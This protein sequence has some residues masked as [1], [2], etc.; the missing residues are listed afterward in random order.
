MN[1][2]EPRSKPVTLDS[3]ISELRPASESPRQ[4]RVLV[5][6]A[7]Y[8][9]R[10]IEFL[11]Q[12][13]RTYQGMS[14]DV[15]VVVLS[16]APKDLGPRVRV[17]VGLPSRNPWSLPFAHKRVFAEHREQY[18]LFVY[19]EDDIGVAEQQIHAFLDATAQLEEDEIAGFLRYEIDSSGRQVLTE[20]WER[21][22]W[23]PESVRRRGGYTIAEFTNE[24]AGFYILTRQQLERAIASGGFLRGP[25]TARY[26]LPET[27]ATDPY[28]SCGFRKVICVS[29]LDKFLIHHLPNKY[30]DVLNMPLSSFQDQIR[31]LMDIGRGAHPARALFAVESRCEASRWMKSYYEKPA[32]EVLGLIPLNARN[33]LSIGCGSGEAETELMRRGVE[34]TALPLDSII[35]AVAGRRGIEIVQGSLEEGMQKL[36][37]RVFDGVFISN[38]LHLQRDPLQFLQKCLPFVGPG[39]ALVLTGPNFARLPWRIQRVLDRG[40]FRRLNR[41]DSSGVT[42]CGPG[43]LARLLKEA[44]VPIARVGWL[45]SRHKQ[46]T[47]FLL[48]RLTARSWAI[49]ARRPGA[50]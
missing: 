27:A 37:G 20:V 40:D 10:Q 42:I 6:I 46:G 31:I 4:L 44:G 16:E 35:G 45:D 26:A 21:H 43:S 48:A 41:F 39:A 11:K 34:V 19:S 22:H 3:M 17:V 8:G 18:D 12:V 15:D 33:V 28:T 38:L 9:E 14:F 13:I 23:K 49:Q 25:Y 5:A 30:V 2:R 32:P 36:R 24:H 47:A 7:S 1:N 50:N 29:T